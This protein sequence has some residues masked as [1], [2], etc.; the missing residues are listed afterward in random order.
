MKGGWGPMSKQDRW[1]E[2]SLRHHMGIG[3]GHTYE[4]FVPTH[5]EDNGPSYKGINRSSHVVGQFHHHH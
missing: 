1:P 2:S 4:W 3:Q 5:S